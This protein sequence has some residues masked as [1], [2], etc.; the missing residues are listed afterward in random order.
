MRFKKGQIVLAR[1]GAL[2][3]LGYLAATVVEIDDTTVKG[4]VGVMLL[5]PPTGIPPLCKKEPWWCGN[6]D[7]DIQVLPEGITQEQIEALVSLR[8]IKNPNGT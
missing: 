7:H 5:S 1:P 8:N 3:H 6:P 2:Y 4:A